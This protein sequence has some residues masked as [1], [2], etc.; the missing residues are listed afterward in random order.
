MSSLSTSST[1]GRFPIS[2]RLSTYSSMFLWFKLFIE[3]N[4]LLFLNEVISGRTADNTLTINSREF[5]L[6]GD[7]M[8]MLDERRCDYDKF[9]N[10]HMPCS[11]V[12]VA[13]KH[14]HHEYR[15]YIHHVYT[16]ENVSNVYK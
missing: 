7:F 8:V 2:R 5:R 16:L 9:Q 6:V 15:N 3:N 11:H 14:A 1:S 10:L 12:V 13:C 4:R